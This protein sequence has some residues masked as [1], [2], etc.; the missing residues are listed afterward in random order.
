MSRARLPARDRRPSPLLTTAAL[1]LF[2]TRFSTEI[3]PQTGLLCLGPTTAGE[4]PRVVVMGSGWAG[5]RL[6]KDIDTKLYDVVCLPRREHMAFTSLLASTCIGILE[7]R[8]VAEP[9]GRIQPAISTSPRPYFYLAKCTR[10]RSPPG[11]GA[12]LCGSVEISLVSIR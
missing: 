10:R 9:I 4:K 1:L 5:C 2:L 3:T 12:S 6:L 8:S 7:F 11:P